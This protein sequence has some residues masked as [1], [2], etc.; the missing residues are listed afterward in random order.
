[1]FKLITLVLV[2]MLAEVEESLAKPNPVLPIVANIYPFSISISLIGWV[3]ST[4]KSLLVITLLNYKTS[5]EASAENLRTN[6]LTL[7]ILFKFSFKLEISLSSIN[8]H[9]DEASIG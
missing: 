3:V 7:A 5:F 6:A 1:L 8:T 2:K 9:A 4:P